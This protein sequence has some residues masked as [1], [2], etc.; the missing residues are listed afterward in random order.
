MATRIVDLA[1]AS[2]AAFWKSSE[3]EPFATIPN[4]GDHTENHPLRSKA[5]KTWLS[6]LLYEAE[7]R[8]PKGSAV[9]DA[10]AV[11]EGRAIFEGET[12]P[13]FVRFAEYGDK[14][15]LDLGGAGWRAVEIDSRGWRVI[16]SEA[17]PVKFRRPKGFME[18]PEPKRGGD[19]EDL[20]RVL[21]V[22]EGAP[23]VLVRAWLVQA[24]K[25]SGPYPVLIVDGEQGS[26]KSW[27]GRSF[28]C[29]RS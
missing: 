17:V 12:F 3:G 11:L 10:L 5:A 22:P 13:V 19:L 27:L 8:A 21:N 23:W 16:S 25:P 6:G 2:G 15:Y 18:L 9:M 7:G 14:F 1:L 20:R 4:G 29:G 24:F 26:G 28:G